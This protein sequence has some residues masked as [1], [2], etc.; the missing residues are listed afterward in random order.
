MAYKTIRLKA[1]GGPVRNEALANAA[2]YPGHLV[3]LLSTGKIRKHAT[4]GGRAEKAFAVENELVGGE[5][6]TV[7]AQDSIVQYEIFRPGDEVYARVTGSPAVGA[8]L[9]SQGDG[10][11]RVAVLDSS[12]IIIEDNVIAILLATVAS[13]FAPVRII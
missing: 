6:G 5:I 2:L 7:Y 1:T 8:F 3:G 4:S 10:T 11:L 9:T 13:S 12:G